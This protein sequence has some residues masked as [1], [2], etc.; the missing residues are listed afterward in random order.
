[1]KDPETLSLDEGPKPQAGSLASRVHWAVP[2]IEAGAQVSRVP[3]WF[4]SDCNNSF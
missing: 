1:M 4:F 2:S 3:T